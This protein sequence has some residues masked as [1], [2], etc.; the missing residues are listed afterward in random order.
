MGPRCVSA[1]PLV[2]LML[3]TLVTPA[4]EYLL[5]SE[6]TGFHIISATGCET[7]ALLCYFGAMCLSSL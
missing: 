2:T 3:A 5:G 7:L 6:G 4:L 1:H